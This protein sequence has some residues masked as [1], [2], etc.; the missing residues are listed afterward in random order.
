MFNDWNT[1]S[2]CYTAP[3]AHYLVFGVTP[4]HIWGD[5]KKRCFYLGF[6]PRFFFI[7]ALSSVH[8]TYYGRN[9]HNSLGGKGSF[10]IY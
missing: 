9:Y 2:F 5:A 1:F 8:K 3:L 6:T 4:G 10:I 7:K